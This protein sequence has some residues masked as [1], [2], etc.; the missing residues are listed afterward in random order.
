MGRLVV[1]GGSGFIGSAILKAAEGRFE[2]VSASRGQV[3][4]TDLHVDL[5]DQSTFGNLKLKDGDV[6]LLL[7]AQ[8]SPDV[9]ANRPEE[10]RAINVTGTSTLLQQAHEAGAKTLFFSTDVVYGASDKTVDENFPSSPAGPYGRMKHEVEQQFL[11]RPLFKTMRLSYVFSI[12]D[13]FTRYA[14]AACREGTEVEVFDPFCRNVVYLHDLV[15]AVLA[16]SESWEMCPSGVVNAGGPELLTRLRFVEALVGAGLKG[17]RYKVVEPPPS[18]FENR[19]RVINMVSPWMDRLV[20]APRL[21]LREAARR[22]FERF[23][24][25]SCNENAH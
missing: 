23:G 15:A 9:C 17:L 8:S 7:A 25:Q 6:L 4:A 21:T 13:K 11:G 22:E 18:F 1:L 3:S 2:V 24:I 20:G 5:S 14:I 16:L 10:A 12:A 19:P